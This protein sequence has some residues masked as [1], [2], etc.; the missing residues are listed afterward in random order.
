MNG[1]TWRAERR[2]GRTREPG[3]G[4]EAGGGD[5]VGTGVEQGA[6]DRHTLQRDEDHLEAVSRRRGPSLIYPGL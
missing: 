4:L 2:D 3:A 5:S 6:A 1:R